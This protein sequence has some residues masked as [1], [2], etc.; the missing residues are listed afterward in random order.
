MVWQRVK[1]IQ[2]QS[3][4]SEPSHDN[5]HKIPSTNLGAEYPVIIRY[6]WTMSQLNS[7]RVPELKYHLMP[8]FEVL[9]SPCFM[10]PIW[11]SMI[12]GNE[13]QGQ[14]HPKISAVIITCFCLFPSCL[15]YVWKHTYIFF[16]SSRSTYKLIWW[17]Q[18]RIRPSSSH[19]S[20]EAWYYCS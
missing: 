8:A 12:P 7:T 17:L 10:R 6:P 1:Y 14:A 18:I 4:S 15:C 16:H 5:P 3:L 9:N 20:K 13:I 2:Q 11:E 19:I